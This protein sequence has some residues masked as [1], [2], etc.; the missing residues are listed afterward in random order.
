MAIASALESS[1]ITAFRHHYSPEFASIGTKTGTGSAVRLISRD[2]GP[3]RPPFILRHARITDEYL[4][5]PAFFRLRRPDRCMPENRLHV[6]DVA[7]LRAVE[8]PDA[9]LASA[10]HLVVE[11]HRPALESNH[12]HHRAP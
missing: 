2:A 10:A 7:A 6:L 9:E 1:R 4:D 11:L 5:L 3:Y 8:R 12:Q